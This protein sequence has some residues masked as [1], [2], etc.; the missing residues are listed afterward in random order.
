MFNLSKLQLHSL[1]RGIDH[2]TQCDLAYRCVNFHSVC[3]ARHL[4]MSIKPFKSYP[5]FV[6]PIGY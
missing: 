3:F 5:I 1:L 6:A 2:H 4:L